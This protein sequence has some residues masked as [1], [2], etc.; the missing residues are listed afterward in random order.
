MAG[1]RFI[2]TILTVALLLIVTVYLRNRCDRI[3]HLA[4]MAAAQQNRLK[5]QLQQKQLRLE[6]YMNPAAVRQQ[7]T[8][9]R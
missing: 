9:D 6:S 4:N 8:E 5:Q 1:F 7:S 2:F 3:C